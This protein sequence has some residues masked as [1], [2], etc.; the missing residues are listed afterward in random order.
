VRRRAT[1]KVKSW[2]TGFAA[3]TVA[4]RPFVPLSPSCNNAS[5]S[6]VIVEWAPQL[7]WRPAT[8]LSVTPRD[9]RRPNLEGRAP[10][11]AAREWVR[12]GGWTDGEPWHLR[13]VLSPSRLSPSSMSACGVWFSSGEVLAVWSGQAGPP[14]AA[15]RCPVC[16]VAS[17]TLRAIDGLP[18]S[19]S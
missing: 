3:V 19:G 6:T 15:D 11:T 8:P 13:P 18:R 12:R 1:A 17:G 9:A 7:A 16:D 14:P 10:M 2:R 5:T 4:G